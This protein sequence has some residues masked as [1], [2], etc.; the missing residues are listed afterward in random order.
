[1]HPFL[2]GATAA[3]CGAASLFFLRFWSEAD[4]PLFAS[5]AG[6]FALLALGYATT[7]IFHFADET[8]PYVFLLR[9]AAFAVILIGIAMKNRS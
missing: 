7:G 6:G 4:E 1:M 2:N 8:R 5:F 3:L 9:F